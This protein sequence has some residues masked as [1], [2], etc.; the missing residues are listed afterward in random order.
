MIFTDHCRECGY[1]QA[2]DY[3]MFYVINEYFEILDK[4]QVNILMTF[5]DHCRECGYDQAIDYKMFYVINEYFEI[6]DKGQVNILMTFT[7][8]CWEYGYDQAIDYK[9]F[10]VINEYFEWECSP[11]ATD[12]FER[13]VSWFECVEFTDSPWIAKDVE[14]YTFVRCV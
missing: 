10:Y 13:T 2:I 4:G 7:D 1:D 8:H 11:R 14:Q 12:V 9:M 3:K 6:L 5:T